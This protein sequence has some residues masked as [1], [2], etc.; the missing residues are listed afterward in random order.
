MH[1][2]REWLSLIVFVAVFAPVYLAVRALTL[3]L[4][5]VGWHRWWPRV[6]PRLGIR[7][8]IL[9]LE[10]FFPESSGYEYR[11]ASWTPMLRASGYTT[12]ARHPLSEDVSGALLDG[13]WAGV[14]YA[15]YLL[16][17][18]PQVLS[19]P[20]YNCVVVRR[21][22]L[23][24]NDYGGV[25]MERLLLALN[26]NVILD[27]DDDIAAAKGEPRQISTV[28][29]LLLE[30]PRKFGDT[31][32]LYPRF[33]AGSGYLR[34]LVGDERGGAVPENIEVIPTCV[35]YD[36]EPAKEYGDRPET[37]TLGWIGTDGNLPQ[38]AKI[39]PDLE[40]LSR[41]LSLRLTVISGSGL[42]MP[43]SFPIENR[44]WSLSTQISDLLEVDIGLMPLRDTRVER[45]KCGFKLIQYMG[46][47]LVGVA[48]AITTN[49]EIVTDG[50]DGFLVEPGESWLDALR[51]TVGR[52]DDFPQIGAAARDRVE[53]AYSVSAHAERYV[54]FIN[55]T[56]NSP[57][58]VAG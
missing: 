51:R 26:P 40:A 49:R 9:F 22:L 25:F 10:I 50:V 20:R 1:R 19:A 27:F 34:Q 56:C 30:N 7:R 16:K 13:G 24:Y 17:R 52:W 6:Q 4:H 3:M 15:A 55:R 12:R 46:L 11:V 47:G 29:R 41:E 45:G 37:I 53:S 42:D 8:R 48:S 39:V 28:G 18:L 36:D 57:S 21:E 32:R 31:L 58:G 14:F 2:S 35:A 54:S 44:H 5:L 38:L 43:A 23:R 33:I